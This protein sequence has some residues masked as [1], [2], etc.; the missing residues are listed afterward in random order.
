MTINEAKM[1]LKKYEVSA[2][3]Y[4]IPINSA[5][6][7]I[8]DAIITLCDGQ[9]GFVLTGCTKKNR[10]YYSVYVPDSKRIH[11]FS[12]DFLKYCLD[13]CEEYNG[14]IFN[15]KGSDLLCN[16]SFNDYNKNVYNCRETLD[17]ILIRNFKDK[18]NGKVDYLML[19]A[20]T[21]ESLVYFTVN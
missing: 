1:H 2:N 21:P 17:K 11:G 7:Y 3:D 16:L 20:F 14:Y 15:G 5:N 12:N 18:L 6:N 13:L 19:I 4:L 10:D 8:T 9:H